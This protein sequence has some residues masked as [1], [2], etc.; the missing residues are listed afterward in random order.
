MNQRG[1]FLALL[2][3]VVSLSV[4]LDSF[5]QSAASSPI[6]VLS[7]KRAETLVVLFGGLATP[8]HPKEDVVLVLEIGGISLEEFQK[9]R[10]K[11]WL[12]VMA[13]KQRYDYSSAISGMVNGKAQIKIA[14]TVPRQALD[15]KLFA[16][17]HPPKSFKAE[18]KIYHQLDLDLFGMP[19]GGV[20]GGDRG[21]APQV[22]APQGAASAGVRLSSKEAEGLLVHKEDPV[23]PPLARM[24]RIQGTVVIDL[25]VSEAGAVS[26]QKLI[27]GHPL[28]VK[29]AMEATG[30]WTYRPYTVAG[31]PRTF[32]T[33]VNIPFLLR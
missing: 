20:A 10:G 28:L 6:K 13:G 23:Y 32:V 8:A 29:A 5:C 26:S 15:F 3:G 33:T 4:A 9:A 30:K 27:S 25:I 21:S 19:P 11:K 12:Y 24:A 2:L 17:D 7:A 1:R 22:P 31:K 14:V 18:E 16:G